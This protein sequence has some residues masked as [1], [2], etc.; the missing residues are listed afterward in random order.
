MS[1]HWHDREPEPELESFFLEPSDFDRLDL[2]QP[3]LIEDYLRVGEVS[4]LF[5][6]KSMYKSF[7]ALDMALS[8]ATFGHWHGHKVR[9]GGRVLMIVGEG[10]YGMQKRFRA[11]TTHHKVPYAHIPI[12]FTRGPVPVLEPGRWGAFRRAFDHQIETRWNGLGPA[13]VVIDTLSTSLGG[14]ENS[15]SDISKFI[16]R[17][18]ETFVL[19]HDCTVL[20]VAHS[21]KSAER[22]ARG[23]YALTANCDSVYTVEDLTDDPPESFKPVRLVA[24]FSKDSETPGKLTLQPTKV[25]L[26]EDDYGREISSLV[27]LPYQKDTTGW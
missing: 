26:G 6:A 2:E 4:L 10:T 24:Q 27:M 20:I 13:L 25:I 9:N 22:G 12:A 18:K 5:A 19:P 23:S 17:L 16:V 21:G 7:I 11:W 1:E 14:D 15:A 8:V 3:A